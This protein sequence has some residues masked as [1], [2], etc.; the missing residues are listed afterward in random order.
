MKELICIK[1]PKGC[2]LHVDD[3]NGYAV[4][5]NS[6]ERGAEYGKKELTNPTRVLTST[7]KVTGSLHRRVSVKSLGELPRGL[8]E[9]A[10]RLLDPIELTAPVHI[11]D[12]VIANILNTG[13]DIV[14]TANR[15][16]LSCFRAEKKTGRLKTTARSYGK[17]SFHSLSA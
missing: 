5:G 4:T 12:V 1:C 11:G 13:I 7:V 8:L 17:K 9:E 14:A 3:E 6:C 15:P 16:A 2:H 10:V